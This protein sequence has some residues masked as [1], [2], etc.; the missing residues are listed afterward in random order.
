MFA[1]TK[2]KKPVVILIVMAF[3]ISY[4]AVTGLVFYKTAKDVSDM[5]ISDRQQAM[6]YVQESLAPL[7]VAESYDALKVNL[8]KAR[9]VNFIDFYIVQSPSG[10]L[11]WYNNFNNLDGINVDYQEY[12]SVLENDDLAFRTI[13]ILDVK[14]TVGVFQNRAKL[15]WNQALLMKWMYL[16]DIAIVTSIVALIVFMLLKDII[17]LSKALSTSTSREEIQNI[18]ATS[19]EAHALINASKGF[20]GERVRLAELSE[21]YGETVG[22]ALRHELKS[23]NKPPYT[24]N[25]TMCRVDLNGYTQIFLEKSDKYLIE[26]L[27]KYFAKAR[28]VIERYDGLI[29]QF[30]GDEIVFHFKDDMANGLSS[31]ALAAA[32]IRDLFAEAKII[33][34]SLPPEA[35]HYFKLKASFSRG[36]MRFTALDEGHALSGLPLIESVRLLSLIDDKTHQVMAFFSEA[37]ANVEGLAFIFDRKLNQLKG[38]KEE[39]MICRSRD[40]NSIEWAYESKQWERLSYFR[41]DSHLLFVLKKARI[42]AV[43][44]RDAEVE[45]ILA[46]LKPFHFHK[47]SEAVIKEIDLA[48]EHFIHSEGENLLGTRSLSA[49]VSL[50]GR[51]ISKEQALPTMT[52]SLVQL[53]DHK[54]ARVQ[55]NAILVLGSYGYPARKIWEKMYSP[56]NRVAADTIVEVAKQQLNEDL[57]RALERLLTSPNPMH[58]KSGEYALQSILDHYQ[59]VD[60]VFFAASPYMERLRNKKTA[61]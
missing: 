50:V 30:V 55:A 53:L 48:L 36:I 51:V 41:S 16:Q 57:M 6:I 11:A 43:T 17:N 42:M 34:D 2:S 9:A 31:E 32:C 26:I 15:I 45:E 13:N 61:A 4:V 60:P 52:K 18:K 3:W 25:A 8:E 10:V 1:K 29:Y 49:L 44:K 28:D 20:E 35:G 23:G 56:N 33:E 58:R 38:F 37:S 22:P 7:M 47:T 59:A 5:I 54:D 46:A 12:G 24:F 19:A 39:S 21:T 40:F 27:N 14:L